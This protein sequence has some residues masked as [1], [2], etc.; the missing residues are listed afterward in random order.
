MEVD[1]SK[2]NKAV[3]AI[4]GGLIGILMTAFPVIDSLVTALGME[5]G[6]IA[7]TVTMW[8]MGLIGTYFA[9]KNAET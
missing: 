8:V 5:P 3:G 2:Y 9:P 7:D 6:T 4:I 1:V